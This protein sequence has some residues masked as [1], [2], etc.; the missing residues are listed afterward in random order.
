MLYIKRNDFKQAVYHLS[1]IYIDRRRK[2]EYARYEAV[3][4]DVADKLLNRF[5]LGIKA[6]GNIALITPTVINYY[7]QIINKVSIDKHIHE[8]AD[9]DYLQ[10]VFYGINPDDPIEEAWTIERQ[11]ARI[12][13]LVKEIVYNE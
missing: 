1:P 3:L 12:T 6:D 8:I 4:Y 13:K 5:H 10:G 2:T 9:G 11:P 7:G